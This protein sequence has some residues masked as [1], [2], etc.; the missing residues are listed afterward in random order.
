MTQGIIR[1]IRN[2]FV[3]DVSQRRLVIGAEVTGQP[4]GPVFKGQTVE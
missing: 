2:L 3:W 1:G 4:I